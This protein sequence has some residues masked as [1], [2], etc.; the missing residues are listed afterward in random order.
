[1]SRKSSRGATIE[2]EDED[3][4]LEPATPGDTAPSAWDSLS[5][6][7]QNELTYGVV[8]YLLAAHSNKQIIKRADVNKKLLG[9]RFLPYAL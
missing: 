3:S 7:V 9:V 5:P 6:E 8:H 2:V 1:M 4:E